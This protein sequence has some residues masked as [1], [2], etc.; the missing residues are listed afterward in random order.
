L[1][2][3]TKE[4]FHNE[5]LEEPSISYE[6]KFR[7]DVYNVTLD[8]VINVMESGFA[9]HKELYSCF[10]YFH[11]EKIS[12]LPTKLSSEILENVCDKFQTFYPEVEI[13][14]LKNELLDFARK[15]KSLSLALPNP[16]DDEDITTIN[17]ESKE[18]D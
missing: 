5:A 16:K 14:V 6:D 18:D 9:R 11:P 1:K 13:E 8:K 17:A 15:W 7:I 3:R 4:T 2:K 10:E 12:T